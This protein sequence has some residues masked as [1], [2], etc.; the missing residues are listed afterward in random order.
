MNRSSVFARSTVGVLALAALA[1]CSEQPTQPLGRPAPSSRSADVVPTAG[2]YLVLA[3]A[4]GFDKTFESSVKALGGSMRFEH[5]GAG[6]AVVSG[7]TPTAAAQLARNSGIAEIDA[8]QTVTLESQAAP[9]RPDALLASA[10]HIAGDVNPA[11]ALLESWQWN[12]KDIRAD[13]AWRAGRLGDPGVTVAIID[14]GIDY[15][16]FDLDGLVD[17]S[18]STSFVPSDDPLLTNLFP[19]LPGR[20]A[21]SDLNGHGTNVATQVSSNAIVF[22][23]VTA[24]TTLIGVKVLGAQG[25]GSIGTILRG[26][27]W[28]ADHGADVANMSIGGNF[29][30]A[31]NGPFTAE[32]NR[33]FS[34]AKQRGMLIVVAAGN[35][36]ANLDHNGNVAETFCD[37]VHVVCVASVGPA[38]ATG[39]RDT[40]AFYTNFGRSA[41]S[42]AGPGGN[43]DAANGFPS[44]AWPWGS[45]IASWVWSLCSKTALV[46]AKDGTPSP[47]GCNSGGFIIGEIGT[48][49]AAPH[50]A[51]LAALLVSLHGHGQ[52]QQIK[53]LIESSADDLGQPGVDPYF[54]HGRINVANAIAR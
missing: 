25:A 40:P 8:D 19:D 11:A 15:D 33:V 35:D 18:R 6:F 42:V 27:L 10:P 31:G 14:S 4:N 9:V 23:G 26:V 37:M 50:V 47:E 29:V 44:S 1:A 22:A 7:L 39:P 3:K 45:D 46:F 43:A 30:K 41:I 51:G 28:A 34:Y 20:A 2:D 16:A 5:Q 52:P 38:T 24:K 21:I 48:S 36:G 13:V 49:Q 54:G 12:M 32:L 53:Q 17:L